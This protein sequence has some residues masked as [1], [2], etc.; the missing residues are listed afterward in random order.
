MAQKKV[1]LYPSDEGLDEYELRFD[2]ED[3]HLEELLES[4]KGIS[5]RS[6]QKWFLDKTIDLAEL[7]EEHGKKL[8]FKMHK[9]PYKKRKSFTKKYGIYLFA[10]FVVLFIIFQIQFTLILG[11]IFTLVCFLVPFGYFRWKTVGKSFFGGLEIV[12][13]ASMFSLGSVT[14]TG[15]IYQP[16]NDYWCPPGYEELSTPSVITQFDMPGNVRGISSGIQCTGEKGTLTNQ[17]IIQIT[18]GYLIWAA[19]T[20]SL[21]TLLYHFYPQFR[22]KANK[23]YLPGMIRFAILFTFLIVVAIILTQVDQIREPLS[24]ITISLLYP[25]L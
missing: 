22:G 4:I 6:D 24:R 18:I 16:F 23:S 10:A 8:N 14:T 19:F 1:S 11:F 20:I 17:F 21:S 25:D 9:K 3:R 2:F 15:F 5:K 7:K 12:F 13:F